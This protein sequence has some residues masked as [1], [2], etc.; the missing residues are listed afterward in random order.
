MEHHLLRLTPERKRH[1]K[2]LC[3]LSPT[4]MPLRPLLALVL[5]IGIG[6]QLHAQRDTL[7]L[8]TVSVTATR[9]PGTLEKTGRH[10]QVLDVRTV[11][12]A[13]RP[14]VSEVLRTHSSIDVRQ[15][16]PFDIQTDLGIRGGTYDQ[17]LVLI[18]GIPMSDPQTG[19]HLMDLPLLSD[20]LERIEVLHGGASRT[21]G[22][23]AFSGAI[24]LITRRAD[25]VKGSLTLDGGE[26]GSWRVRA[27]QEWA[28][29]GFGIRVA[30]FHGRSDGA[31]PNSDHEQSGI[32]LGVTE[33][34]KRVELRGQVG[35]S[36]KRFG[37]QNF[38][39]SLYPDQQEYTRT[40]LGAIELRHR[41]TW[42]WSVR[43]YFRQH[44]DRFELFR[45]GPGHYRY[46]NGYFIRGEAD[47]AR[48]TPTFFYTFHNMHRTQVAGAE[49]EIHRGWK[50]GTTALGLHAR[51]EDILSNVLGEPLEQPI[52]AAG[53]RDPYTRSD[54]RGNL[55]IHLDHRYTWE[56]LTADAGVLLNVN[57]AFGPEW[58]PGM[59]LSYAWNAH[60]RTYASASRAFRLPTYTD[61]Y[62]NRGG[63]V[64]SLDL[65]PEH[66]DQIE[67]GHRYDRGRL[68]TTLATFMRQGKDLIDWVRLPGE[69]TVR[70]ANITEVTLYGVEFDGVWIPAGGRSRSG[71]AYTYQWSDRSSFDFTSLYV[72][73]QLRHRFV[74]WS[75]RRFGAFAL[76]VNVGW[77]QRVGTY[78][79]FVDG[80]PKKYP[81]NFRIDP[82]L[83]WD[84]GPVQ[85][86]ISG[87]NVLN[88][89]Q[90]DRANVL[91]PG[92][93]ISG[94]V[95]VRWQ[96]RRKEEPGQ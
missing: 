59:D 64:G 11:Q 7:R 68:S 55:A 33:K 8:D 63:A 62:Y 23:G 12:G 89:E 36:S 90:M 86:F 10:L 39:S 13:A 47:T 46:A 73:D 26:Y 19:H 76:R 81:D 83:S 87:Y 72:L 69:N 43:G 88:T 74:V 51:Q 28:K 53:S 96:Q 80:T 18:D 52:A 78:V 49:A 42:S 37:A 48:F 67:L 95:T 9:I 91:L 40:L 30:A 41:G 58:L 16:G 77:Q 56:R 34:W 14:E 32:H 4:P 66:G 17:A 20:A 84:R 70:A 85:L 71:M 15:R 31:V 50:G 79:D 27:T 54:G 29:N 93:W 5:I 82:R 61:L 1:G 92:R 35:F 65:R 24:N 94:G 45:E 2:H 60:H 44:N 75:E 6:T 21:F 57:S 25:G 22:A 3:T 38:Y